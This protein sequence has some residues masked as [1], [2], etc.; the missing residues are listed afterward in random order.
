MKKIYAFFCFIF[1]VSCS[2]GQSINTEFG[3][4]RVQYHNDFTNWW[5]YETENF[6]TYWYGKAKNVAIPSIQ[7]A[8]MDFDEIQKKLEHRI[9]DKIEIIV[10]TDLTD[11]KQSNI[12]LSE[13]FLNQ[14][15]KTKV[16]GNKVFVYFNGDHQHLHKQIKGGTATIFMNSLLFGSSLQEMVQNAVSV[17]VPDWYYHGLIS[18]I[19][20]GWDVGSDEKLR[21]LLNRKKR[22]YKNFDKLVKDYPDLAGQAMWYYLDLTYGSS[23]LSNLLYLSRINRSIESGYIYVLGFNFSEISSDWFQF[24]HKLYQEEGPTFNRSIEPESILIKEKCIINKIQLSPDGKQL[25]FARNNRDRVQVRLLNLQNNQQ[26]KLFSYGNVNGLQETDTN[27]PLLAWSPSGEELSIVY[28]KRDVIYHRKIDLRTGVETQE[29]FAPEYQRVYSLS[30][31]NDMDF[32]ISAN[33]DGFSDL[34]YYKSKTRVSDRLTHDFY[35]DLDARQINYLSRSGILFSSNRKSTELKKMVLDTVLPLRKFDLWFLSLGDN[36]TLEKI[37][38]GHPFNQRQSVIIGTANVLFLSDKSGVQN[39]QL[40]SDSSSDKTSTPVNYHFLTNFDRNII[41]HAMYGNSYYYVVADEKRHYLMQK[42]IDVQS[43]FE[44]PITNARIRNSALSQHEIQDLQKRQ[45]KKPWVQ[46]DRTE[47]TESKNYPEA[48]KFQ[49]E[50]PDPELKTPDF[51]SEILEEN[52]AIPL[53]PKAEGDGKKIIKYNQVRATASRLNFRI[54]DY[55]SKLDNSVLFEGLDSYAGER[56]EYNYT[57]MGILMKASVKDLFEDYFIEG[58]IR[59]P[60]S[61]S[62]T[63]LFLVL[64]DKKKRFDKRYALYRKTQTSRADIFSFS[65][66]KSR[67]NTFLA[68]FQIRYPFDIFTSIRASATLRNDRFYELSS[69][70]QSFNEPINHTQ[71]LGLKLEYVFDNTIVRDLNLLTGMRYKFYVEAV[72]RFDIQITNPRSFNPSEAFM[73]IIGVDVRKYF[74]LDKRSIFAMRLAGATSFGSEKTLFFLGGVENWFLPQFEQNIPLPEGDDFAYKTIAPNMRGFNYNVRNGSSFALLNNEIR[75]PVFNYLTK[76]K[77][78]YSFFRHFQLISFFDAGLAWHG[79]SPYSEKN[80]LN[81]IILENP[82]TVTVK[83]NYFRD[84]IVMGY[85][86]G[87]RTMVLGYFLRFDYA[88][89]IETR[90]IQDPKLYISFGTDF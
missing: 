67:K 16:V 21:N 44:A 17:N 87:F 79:W 71:R 55:T 32:A 1:F 51:I 54:D 81:S 45:L 20:D 63:E 48:Y 38:D 29:P 58:G 65:A 42:T 88:W 50:F 11:L 33:T 47:S 3:K 84:P 5:K 15:G 4:N 77:I 19:K 22:P 9:N 76:R 66:D 53:Q 60:T 56:E 6:I 13:S 62:G 26:Q 8:E 39:L 27:Y 34:Y 37:G 72:N 57:P 46:K 43:T 78:R 73:T 23:T 40:V 70:Q 7:M 14:A 75:F 49:A 86:F 36:P 59:V 82:P 52:T 68:L 2:F 31:I 64:D 69:D 41:T 83:V 61:F 35:D 80:P 74:P 24:F 30:Y 25:L 89:G 12:G 85:G 10:Y 28:E 90:E 18:F